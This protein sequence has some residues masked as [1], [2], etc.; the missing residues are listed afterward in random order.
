VRVEY[1]RGRRGG[2][3]MV[4]ARYL[5]RDELD[6][7]R[8]YY[9][10]VFRTEGWEVGNAEFYQDEWTFL[11]I[12]VEREAD[13]EIEAHEGGVTGVDI[14]L[15]EPEETVSR[16]TP[17]EPRA[18]PDRQ[19]RSTTPTATPASQSASPAPQSASP[20]P[21]YYGDDGDDFGDD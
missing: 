11:V 15:T 10:G 18:K 9:R 20:A 14:E 12:H 2:L 3:E 17:R 13:I 1:E 4:H 21:G 5:T 8:G 16:M 19:P 7:V 6:A